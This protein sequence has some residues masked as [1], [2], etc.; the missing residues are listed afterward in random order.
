MVKGP[1]SDRLKEE[2]LKKCVQK[3]FLNELNAD[4]EVQRFINNPAHIWFVREVI[5]ATG[6]KFSSLEN[7]APA[8]LWCAF[9]IGLNTD[10]NFYMSVH[11]RVKRRAG[12]AISKRFIRKIARLDIQSI[13]ELGIRNGFHIL[14]GYRA[15]DIATYSTK[16]QDDMRNVNVVR[17]RLHKFCAGDWLESPTEKKKQLL[18]E[19][20]AFVEEG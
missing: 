2:E 18:E 6:K 13:M 5:H 15:S 12:S 17:N 14:K 16:T 4:P 3:C 1:R 11:L 20:S 8:T 7:S 19:I 10:R 9:I